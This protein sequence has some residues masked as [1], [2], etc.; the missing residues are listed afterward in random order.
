MNKKLLVLI[1]VLLLL[2][3]AAS[4]ATKHSSTKLLAL[5]HK[6]DKDYG[7]VATLSLDIQP[8]KNRVFLET[9]PLT[10]V[11]TQVSMRFAQQIACATIDID[12]SEYDFFYTI[13]ALPGVVGGPS[14]GA[15]AAVTTAALLL[16]KPLREDV[17]ITGTINSGGIIGS[18]GGLKGKIKAA[19]DNGVKHV[20][21]PKG[22]RMLVEKEV[23]VIE[24]KPNATNAT[25]L[26]E[27]GFNVTEKDIPKLDLVEY[28]R[29]LSVNV[30]EV[31]TLA[32]AIEIFTGY[33]I[34]E[35]TGDFV[36]DP[37]YKE[38]MKDVAVQLCARN[39]E[40]KEELQKLREENGINASE[41][42]T[43]ALNYSEKSK[44]S[45][46]VGEYYSAASYCFRGSV[47][48]KQLVY[49][50]K[51]FTE[52]DFENKVNSIEK[53]I[54]SFTGTINKTDIN[55]IT[56]LQTMMAVKERIAEAREAIDTAIKEKKNAD[57]LDWLAY[58][59]ERLYSAEAWSKFFNGD[60]NE[61]DLDETRLKATC[62]SKINE[63]EERYNYLRTFL[64]KV[65]QGIRGN[66][67]D[68]YDDLKKKDYVSCLYQSIKVK[69]EIDV[70][71]GLVG[72][73]DDRIDELLDLKLNI[74]KQTLVKT[75]KKGIFPIISYSYYEYANSLKESEKLP[76]SFS[77]L[78]FSEYALEFANLDIYFPK[79]E[80]TLLT[81]V[82]KIDRKLMLMFFLGLLAGIILMWRPKKEYKTLQTPP[83]KRLRGKKR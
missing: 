47:T 66:L 17:A 2:V 50:L 33:K 5:L 56:A 14:A 69:S 73:E 29:N 28:G 49:S 32:E 67:D 44:E 21:I 26:N 68:A 61:F 20:L 41:R 80:K 30:T 79:K 18:V 19:S 63:A 40:L 55:T 82:K 15:S 70:V 11:T 13:T 9:F 58:S 35:V 48:F 78:L 27:T 39:K 52:E 57:K 43:K 7:A 74:V 54:D 45:F 34:K 51:N 10:Q 53:D 60:D 42:E 75:Q 12:C 6:K 76:D 77:A 65:L 4:A 62:Q 3:P 81:V 72:V 38:T 1:L 16:D 64:P 23:E 25:E 8:G 83:K 24:L 37:D 31:A 59:E 22:T 71:L 46:D 36:I